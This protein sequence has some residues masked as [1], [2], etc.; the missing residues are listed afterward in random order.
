MPK[1]SV[2][3]KT[4]AESEPRNTTKK[5][6]TSEMITLLSILGSISLKLNAQLE[7]SHSFGSAQI[8]P[9]SS[10]LDL[11]D[12]KKVRMTGSM[13]SSTTIAMTI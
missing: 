9:A 10:K 11:N 3:T 1:N 6:A 2:L 7:K 8:L 13:T 12:I 5:V 4:N